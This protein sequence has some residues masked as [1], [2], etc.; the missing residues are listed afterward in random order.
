LNKYIP[1]DWYSVIWRDTGKK[2]CD[3][4]W[5]SD[6]QRI[7]AAR[8]HLLTYIKSSNHLMGQVIDVEV[9]KELPTSNIVMADGYSTSEDTVEYEHIND[10]PHDGWWLKPEHQDYQKSLPESEL[11]P[12]IPDFHD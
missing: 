8:P 6:A 9:P 12:F 10:D 5:E 7:V 3:C 4:G 1:Q 2:Y 11:E